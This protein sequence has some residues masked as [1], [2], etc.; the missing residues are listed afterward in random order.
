[1]HIDIQNTLPYLFQVAL[2]LVRDD[3]K[4]NCRQM[5]CKKKVSRTSSSMYF[6]QWCWL[7]HRCEYNKTTVCYIYIL[8]KYIYIYLTIYL[9][10]YIFVCE[11]H[12]SCSKHFVSIR[13]LWDM[14]RG[15]CVCCRK[16]PSTHK[17]FYCV[18]LPCTACVCVCVWS[19]VACL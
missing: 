13:W 14:A 5:P 19:D 17:A 2:V 1:M 12:F 9:F 16:W 10:M 8:H 6:A 18:P 11:N 4:H 15:V 7:S 3:E